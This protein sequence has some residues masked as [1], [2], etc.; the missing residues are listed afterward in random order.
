MSLA[1]HYWMRGAHHCSAPPPPL[2]NDLYCVEWDVKLYCTIPYRMFQSPNR[3]CKGQ[4][5]E[6]VRAERFTL[7]PEMSVKTRNRVGGDFPEGEMF[8]F[9]VCFERRAA[10][11][12]HRRDSFI[13]CLSRWTDVAAACRGTTVDGRATVYRWRETNSESWRTMMHLQRYCSRRL[14]RRS[15]FVLLVYRK[16][17]RYGYTG[18][19]K[20]W[21]YIKPFR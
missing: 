19:K 9:V 16:Q 20:V 8:L 5:I 7:H 3:Q 10:A 18:L 17:E 6:C 12:T 2:R 13:T 14:F 21:W 1:L 4:E 15:D 11:D